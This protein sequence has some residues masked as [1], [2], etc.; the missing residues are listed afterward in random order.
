MDSNQKQ[1]SA[2]GKTHDT[3]AA[4]CEKAGD[5]TGGAWACDD[6]V[7]R[8]VWRSINGVNDCDSYCK[9]LGMEGGSCEDGAKDRSSWCPSGQQCNCHK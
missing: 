8:A 4:V 5:L 3:V 1:T 7:S 6:S 2:H 9:K